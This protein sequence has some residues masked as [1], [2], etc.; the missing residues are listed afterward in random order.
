MTQRSL[1][2]ALKPDAASIDPGEVEK[3]G[4]LAAEW[5]NPN[6]PMK[7]LHQI[8]PVRLA[9]LRDQICRQFDRD[10]EK[11]RPFEGLK[12]LDIGCGA[13]L[14]CEPMTRL[15]A[16]VTG[17][18]PAAQNVA[19][20]RLHAEDADLEIDYREITVEAIAAS[21]E[22]FDVVLAMEVVEHV[23][24]VPAFVKAAAS[25]LKPGGLLALSTLNRTMRSFALAIVGA[26]YVLR[27]LPVGT[28]DW[29]KF[30][31][32]AELEQA[33]TSAGLHQADL[34]GMIFNPLTRQ[35][36]LAR[37]TAVNYFLTAS[38]A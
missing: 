7:P 32:P 29:E 34:T 17:I 9:Y 30:V 28:H 10:G 35:W 12:L 22:R 31:T 6:G 38:H 33:V 37:D 15:G 20:A 19:V 23:N 11:Y 24:D 18:D 4:R 1:N 14:L 5:W 8:N 2:A 36:S 26:E 16:D 21:D 3:F 13:G 25:C 27:W